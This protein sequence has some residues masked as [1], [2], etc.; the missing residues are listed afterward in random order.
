M[1]GIQDAASVDSLSETYSIRRSSCVFADVTREA[2]PGVALFEIVA[3]GLSPDIS[4]ASKLI[5]ASQMSSVL[6]GLSVARRYHECFMRDC[7][8]AL[9]TQRPILWV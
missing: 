8:C 6:Y 9:D 2:S 5:L 1:T 3:P 7:N 4:S